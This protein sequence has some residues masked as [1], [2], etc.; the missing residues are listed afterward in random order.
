VHIRQVRIAVADNGLNV[1][2]LE[3]QA[4]DEPFVRYFTFRRD[5]FVCYAGT[6]SD[7]AT[8]GGGGSGFRKI[9]DLDQKLPV[10]F[11][12]DAKNVSPLS[13]TMA[14]S[15]LCLFGENEIAV[16]LTPLYTLLFKEVSFYCKFT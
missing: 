5:K 14:A 1:I 11:F 9:L 2:G 3:G 10:T 16:G 8:V 6:K 12:R 4:T 15:R 7:K 13:A